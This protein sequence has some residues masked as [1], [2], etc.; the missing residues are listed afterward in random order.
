MKNELYV[1]SLRRYTLRHWHIYYIDPKFIHYTERIWL[2]WKCEFNL[3]KSIRKTYFSRN[4]PKPVFQK[5][6]NN[7]AN[8]FKAL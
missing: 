4:R 8:E 5:K 2:S 7:P 6:S 3:P 1:L